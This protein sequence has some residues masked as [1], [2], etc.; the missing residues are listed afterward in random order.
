MLRGTLIEPKYFPSG[1]LHD[2]INEDVTHRDK[3]TSI[4]NSWM[5]PECREGVDQRL[6]QSVCACSL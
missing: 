3:S 5:H 6:D 4:R 1:A 2:K